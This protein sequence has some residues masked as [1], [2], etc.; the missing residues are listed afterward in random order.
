[1]LV[2]LTAAAGLL[3]A[4]AASPSPARPPPSP[5]VRSRPGDVSP[6]L[7]IRPWGDAPAATVTA[8]AAPGAGGVM[9]PC[10]GDVC[11]PRV[12]VPGYEPR[13]ESVS[14]TELALSYLDR[15]KLEPFATIAWTLLVTGLRLDYSPPVSDGASPAPAGW[16]TVFVRV[17]F[18]VDAD[19]VPVVPRRPRDQP[20]PVR[21]NS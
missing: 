12:S 14:R 19:N 18:R 5:Q 17:R 16:G 15:V 9:P 11:Q 10:V 21:G 8:R 6:D 3:A 2:A 13:Y 4:V 20:S 7:R 1:V